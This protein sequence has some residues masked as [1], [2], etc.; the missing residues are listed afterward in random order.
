M[1]RRHGVTAGRARSDGEHKLG[2]HGAKIVERPIEVVAGMTRPT[3][4]DPLAGV[5][6][7]ALARN[8]TLSELRTY[9]EHAR[10]S[11][12]SWDDIAAALEV[13]SATGDEPRGQKVYLLLIE[14][15]SLTTGVID[16]GASLGGAMDLQERAGRG[17][18]IVGR[19]RLTRTTSSRATCGP[20]SGI[21]R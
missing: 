6:A 19:S 14:G 7:A 8:V 18:Q 15:R 9:A 10:G 21:P 1:E 4:D 5:R 13:E 12:R 2:I 17:S 20:A 11:G 16:V 3:L